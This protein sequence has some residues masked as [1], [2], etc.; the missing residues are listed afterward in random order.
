M[1]IRNNT[2]LRTTY[3]YYDDKTYKVDNETRTIM[4]LPSKTF[5]KIRPHSTAYIMNNK[6]TILHT[7]TPKRG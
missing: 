3:T 2:K 5:I 1:V 6:G 4:L 7:I